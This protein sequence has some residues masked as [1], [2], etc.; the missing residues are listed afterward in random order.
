MLRIRAKAPSF[1]GMRDSRPL[2]LDAG[3]NIRTM[4]Q[5]ILDSEKNEVIFGGFS[6]QVEALF[7]EEPPFDAVLINTIYPPKLYPGLLA[8]IKQDWCETRGIL[9]SKREEAICGLD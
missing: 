9:I 2:V 1:E 7:Q 6:E 8:T 3:A 4:V 5:E